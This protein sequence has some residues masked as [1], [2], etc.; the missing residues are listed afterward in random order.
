MTTAQIQ[1]GLA[2]ALWDAKRDR[3]RARELAHAARDHLVD[4]DKRELE[5]WLAKHK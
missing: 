3:A 2:R 4:N 5:A 1:F